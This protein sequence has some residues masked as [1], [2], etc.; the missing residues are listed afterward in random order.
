MSNHTPTPWKFEDRS[1]FTANDRMNEIAHVRGY[2]DAHPE[3]LTEK[4]FD[5]DVANAEHIVK[6]VN[7]REQIVAAL[8][9]LVLDQRTVAYLRANDP[10]ALKQARAALDKARA[11]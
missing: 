11:K 10:Q 5:E 6:C 2:D 9:C 8:A 7:E 1:I 3:R 4:S